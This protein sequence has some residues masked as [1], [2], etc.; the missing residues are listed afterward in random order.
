MTMQKGEGYLKKEISF[1]R[2]NGGEKGEAVSG[3]QGAA[4]LHQDKPSNPNTHCE[5]DD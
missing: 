5:Y 2:L 4:T 1:I 3:G